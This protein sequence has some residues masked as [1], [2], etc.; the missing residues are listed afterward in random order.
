MQAR[1]VPKQD[2]SGRSHQLLQGWLRVRARW[3]LSRHRCRCRWAAR[4]LQRQRRFGLSPLMPH[5]FLLAGLLAPERQHAG[6]RVLSPL[7]SPGN[8]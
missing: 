1:N 5:R 3:S 7:K 2:D 8:R 4:R 6:M